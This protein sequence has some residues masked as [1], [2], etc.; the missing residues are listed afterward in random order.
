MYTKFDANKV[1][2]GQEGIPG[3]QD[4]R[5]RNREMRECQ[6]ATLST[7]VLF[8]SLSFSPMETVIWYLW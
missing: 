2:F 6:H 4:Y 5:T 7:I 8:P 3:R 1:A